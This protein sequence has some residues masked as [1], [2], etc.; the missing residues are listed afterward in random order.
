METTWSRS[1]NWSHVV[2]PTRENVEKH[3][4]WFAREEGELP[5]VDHRLN[6]DI[7]N[8]EVIEKFIAA[9]RSYFDADPKR[10]MFSLEPNDSQYYGNS[11]SL[12]VVRKQLGAEAIS[13]DEF[14][15]FCNRVAAGVKKTHPDK[16]LGFYAYGHHMW[17]PRVEKPDPMLSFMMCRHGSR[18]CARHSLLD[19]RNQINAEWRKNFEQWSSQLERRGYYGYWGDYGWFG[20]T[21]LNRLADD[22]PYLKRKK[23][24]QLNS[25]N[26]FSWAT[27]AP[28][29]YLALRLFQDTRLNASA[30]LDDFSKGTY[31][32]AFKPMKRYW[33][34]W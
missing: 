25:E 22:L 2:P 32:S 1:H 15:W 34:R 26:R 31:G 5:K 30:V 33:T 20:P 12:Q 6:V 9:A 3:P 21:P 14:V 10:V 13:S 19:P 24:Y 17:A 11:K 23:V 16:I 28:Y 7:S 27:N 29:Y 8:P 4:E 18:A